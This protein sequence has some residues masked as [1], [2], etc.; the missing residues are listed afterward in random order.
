M[1]ES[2][3]TEST[4]ELRYFST[5]EYNLRTEINSEAAKIPARSLFLS[6]DLTLFTECHRT[7]IRESGTFLVPVTA[8]ERFRAW[9]CGAWALDLRY[10]LC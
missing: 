2:S 9:G 8:R 10:S 3:Y 4:S 5:P 6:S 1:P 7:E